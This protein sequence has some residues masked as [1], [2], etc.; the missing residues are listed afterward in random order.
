MIDTCYNCCGSARSGSEEELIIHL[1][2]L[3]R[4]R[5]ENWPDPQVNRE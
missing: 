4:T 5:E 1:E 3:L 2:E